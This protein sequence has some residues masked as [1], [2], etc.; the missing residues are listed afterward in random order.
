MRHHPLS[1]GGLADHPSTGTIS[2][3]HYSTLTISFVE[4]QFPFLTLT[5]IPCQLKKAKT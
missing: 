4:P 3:A 5:S 1:I 2:A